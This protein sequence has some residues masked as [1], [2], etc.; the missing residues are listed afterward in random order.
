MQEVHGHCNDQIPGEE[1]SLKKNVLGM[2]AAMLQKF[3]PVNNICEHVA[4]FHFYSGDIKRQIVA[5]HFCSVINEDFRQ[6]L[7][8]DSNEKKAK[9]IG[10][11]YIISEKLYKSLPDDEARYWHSHIYEVKSGMLSCPHI[12]LIAEKEVMKEL[13]STYGKTIHLWQIDRGDKLPFGPPQLMMA[14]TEDSQVNWDLIKKRDEAYNTDSEERRADRA[15]I[16]EPVKDL[17]ADGWR[18]T[19]KAVQFDVKEFSMSE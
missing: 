9:L 14:F 19:G 7:I 18:I 11:E 16:P 12:P 6:C 13:I 8:Y 15:D 10:V 5:H 2:G 4:G 1:T 3:A 17:R